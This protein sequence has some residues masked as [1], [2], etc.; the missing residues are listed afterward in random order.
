MFFE[1]IWAEALS[2]PQVAAAVAWVTENASNLVIIG[3]L[4]VAVLLIVSSRSSVSEDR[5][6]PPQR[7]GVRR[8]AGAYVIGAELSPELDDERIAND[9]P[10]RVAAGV[11]RGESGSY[12][13]STPYLLRLAERCSCVDRRQLEAFLRFAAQEAMTAEGAPQLIVPLTAGDACTLAKVA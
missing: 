11:A 8:L 9:G 5:L 2:N 4:A 10:V 7:R 3:V 1:R 13:F 6:Q 12:L